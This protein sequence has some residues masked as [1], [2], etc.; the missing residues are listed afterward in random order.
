MVNQ[1]KYICECKA[2]TQREI[3]TAIR[4][5]GARTLLDVQNLTKASTGCSRCKTV[6]NDIV[7]KEMSKLR[8]QG[9]QLRIDF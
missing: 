2:V 8:D 3:I 1:Q 9:M 7:D 5:K 6:V 4:R